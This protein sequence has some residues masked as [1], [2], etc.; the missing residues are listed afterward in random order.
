M[1]Y[2]GYVHR[3]FGLVFL[4]VYLGNL[5]TKTKP[6]S[7]KAG[8]FGGFRPLFFAHILGGFLRAEVD[9]QFAHIIL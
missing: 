8:N 5:Q 7:W 6:E 9:I 3:L 1:E 2:L 4:I